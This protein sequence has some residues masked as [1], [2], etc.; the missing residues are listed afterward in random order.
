M[1]VVVEAEFEVVEFL[2]LRQVAYLK[3]AH[4]IIVIAAVIQVEVI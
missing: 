4:D 3:L 1:Y 2:E